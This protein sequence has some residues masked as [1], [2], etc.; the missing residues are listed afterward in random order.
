MYDFVGRTEDGL[1][2][3]V[4]TDVSDTDNDSAE[5]GED[6]T[7]DNTENSSSKRNLYKSVSIAVYP[8]RFE[9]AV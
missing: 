5:A 6:E 1:Y 8:T 7:V 2:Y 9:P 4:K 3:F